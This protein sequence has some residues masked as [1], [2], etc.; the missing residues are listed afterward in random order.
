MNDQLFYIL[1][2][3]SSQLLIYVIFS[4]IS[5]SNFNK[6]GLKTLE[7]YNSHFH[8]NIFDVNSCYVKF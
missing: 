7:N 8:N 3:S 6:L 1:N 2:D 5:V 4:L